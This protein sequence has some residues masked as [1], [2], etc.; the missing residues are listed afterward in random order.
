MPKVVGGLSAGWQF[1]GGIVGKSVFVP[2]M[3]R[4]GHACIARTAFGTCHA[5]L[6]GTSHVSEAECQ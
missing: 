5:V 1:V 3:L 2:L 6:A 4:S